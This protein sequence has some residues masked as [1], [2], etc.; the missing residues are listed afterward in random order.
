MLSYYNNTYF[1]L[2]NE[3]RFL[4]KYPFFPSEKTFKPIFHKHPFIIVS[5]SHFLHNLRE[6]GY[7]TF[8]GFIDESYDEEIDMNKRYLKIVKEVKRLC[9]LNPNEL[10]EFKKGCLE[11]VEYN[12]NSMMNKTEFAK[13]LI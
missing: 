8:D 6:Q 2:V 13:K 7:R 12:F 10:I 5:T 9:N 11:I 3:T 1:S 4:D